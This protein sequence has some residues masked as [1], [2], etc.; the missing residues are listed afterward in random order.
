[1]LLAISHSSN[2]IIY[3]LSSKSFRRTVFCRFEDA[4]FGKTKATKSDIGEKSQRVPVLGD[5]MRAMRDT[6]VTIQQSL[7][8]GMTHR[9]HLRERRYSL[10]GCLSPSLS[11]NRKPKNSGVS[12][13]P[14]DYLDIALVIPTKRME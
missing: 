10:Y 3:C 11:A 4:V 9:E 13:E 5:E 14:A 7:E 1:M 6:M 12:Q 2:L 8:Q